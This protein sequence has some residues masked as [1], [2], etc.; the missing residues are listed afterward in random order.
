M[1]EL[2]ESNCLSWVELHH[3]HLD[4]LNL[5]TSFFRV[6]SFVLSLG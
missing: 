4:M 3:L 5:N 2:F 6:W 1:V